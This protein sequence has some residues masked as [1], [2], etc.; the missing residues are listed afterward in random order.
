MAATNSVKH[1]NTIKFAAVQQHPLPTSENSMMKD[2]C[3]NN[4]S[5]KP[6]FKM[7]QDVH[8]LSSLVLHVLVL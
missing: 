4:L 5:F 6:K 7:A 2:S 3:T 8:N 1:S